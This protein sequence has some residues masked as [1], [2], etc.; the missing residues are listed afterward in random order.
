MPFQGGYCFWWFSNPGRRGVPLALG[1]DALPLQGNFC[2]DAIATE[3]AGGGQAA[4]CSLFDRKGIFNAQTLV[5][6]AVGHCRPPR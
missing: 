2:V 4:K 1:Y 3:G 6:Q 5:V